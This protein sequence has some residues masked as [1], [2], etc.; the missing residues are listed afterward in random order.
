VI[1]AGNLGTAKALQQASSTVPIVFAA[2]PDP[3]G[4]G[5]VESLARP[6]GN[7]TGFS[8]SEYSESGKLVGLLK[9]IAPRVTRMA[10]IRDPASP[11]G[12]ASWAQSKP[13][14]HRSG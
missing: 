5:V 14:R 10:V 3:V 2:G 6:G 12:P 7:T 8:S 9:E 13:L 4:S 11:A 1:V